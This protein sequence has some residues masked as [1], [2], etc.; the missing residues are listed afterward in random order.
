MPEPSVY[1]VSLPVNS[2]LPLPVMPDISQGPSLP[3]DTTLHVTSFQ[4]LR[5]SNRALQ[6]QVSQI[7][8]MFK[9]FEESS[10]RQETLLPIWSP[11][12]ESTETGDQDMEKSSLTDSSLPVSSYGGRRRS[13]SPSP[14]PPE[15]RARLMS[16]SSDMAHD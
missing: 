1:R 14:Y 8:D 13:K 3:S 12:S 16:A 4:E 2:Q 11:Y 7:A 15:K 5:A 6:A 9:T 10:S